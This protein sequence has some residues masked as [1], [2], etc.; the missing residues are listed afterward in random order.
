MWTDIPNYEVCRLAKAKQVISRRTDHE[1]ATQGPF[2]RV[3]YDLIPMTEAYNKDKWISHFRCYQTGMNHIYTH[4]KKS[5]A[6]DVVQEYCQMIQIRY[7]ASLRFFRSDG[8]GTLGTRFDQL[9]QS[10]GMVSERTAPDTP[11]QNGH[12]ER[13]GGVI[14]STARSMRIH[15]RLP[16][17]LWP[18]IVKTAGYLLNRTPTKALTWKTS[19]ELVTGNKPNLSH[20]QVY[21]CKAYSLSHG[22]P[23]MHKLRPR[24]LI[25]Y[26]IGYDSTNIYRIWLPTQDRVI[27]TRDVTFNEKALYD[28]NDTDL[29]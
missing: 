1:E 26:L 5:D 12:S 8:E 3:S 21:G 19:F 17:N 6:N 22:I 25:G 23:R 10:R 20:L 14:I 13:S 29:T 2:D 9:I 7:N 16:E 27:R 18:E 28:P 4:P 11:S 15:A 24:A